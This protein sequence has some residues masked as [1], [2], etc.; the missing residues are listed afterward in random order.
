MKHFICIFFLFLFCTAHI[1]VAQQTNE[2]NKRTDTVYSLRKPLQLR[3]SILVSNKS[4][5]FQ[6]G[7]GKTLAHKEL[8]KVKKGGKE[9]V[10]LK[11][12]ILSLNLGYYY[13]PGLHQNWFVTAAYHIKRTGRK[14]FYTELSPMLGVSR[15]FLLDEAY[16]VSSNGTVTKVKLAGSWYLASGFSIGAGKTFAENKNYWLKD[17]NLQL[18]TQVFYPEFR[19]IAFKPSLQIGT[20]L[21]IERLQRFS[22]QLIQYKNK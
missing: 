19:F 17:I 7:I 18:F 21:S 6:T 14:G 13:Q 12:K 9:K 8:H 3:S 22:K 2:T 10:V 1:A 15:T 4:I 5:G 20:S 11:D 16:T